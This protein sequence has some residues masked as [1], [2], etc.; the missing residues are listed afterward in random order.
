MPKGFSEEERE[1]IKEALLE[2]GEA[3]FS[4]VGFEKTT[5]AELAIQVGISKG[6]FYL[7]FTSKEDL[8]MSLIARFEERTRAGIEET[9]QS[10]PTARDGLRAV[11]MEQLEQAKSNPLIGQLMTGDLLRRIWHRSSDAARKRSIGSDEEFLRELIGK[12]GNLKVSPEVASGMLRALALVTVHRD[13]VGE[14]IY[15]EVEGAL[16]EAVVDH[17]MGGGDGTN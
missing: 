4:R 3:L 13:T 15:D 16:V 5:V 12:S 10:A 11:V 8:L 17:I 9:F 1:R 2:T 7:F 6:A 14:Q